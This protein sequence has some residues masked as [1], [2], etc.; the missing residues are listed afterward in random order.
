MTEEEAHFHAPLH[1]LLTR[2]W[3]EDEAAGGCMGEDDGETGASNSR[4]AP[5]RLARLLEHYVIRRTWGGRA[6]EAEEEEEEGEEEEE[7]LF[8]ADAVN[9]EDSEHDRATQV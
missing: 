1:V 9:E 4:L 8:K 5:M 6:W 7:S 2:P 3:D